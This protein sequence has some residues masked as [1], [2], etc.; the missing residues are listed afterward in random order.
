MWDA[1]EAYG[2]RRECINEIKNW[3]WKKSVKP[4]VLWKDLVNDKLLARLIKKRTHALLISR[5]KVREKEN[6]GIL[7]TIFYH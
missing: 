1:S 7:W 5:V 3:Q 6:K 2:E 4:K